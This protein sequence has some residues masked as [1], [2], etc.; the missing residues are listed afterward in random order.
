MPV[1]VLVVVGG[2]VIGW[3][4]GGRLRAL[5]A[6]PL[7][8]FALLVVALA[9]QLAGFLLAGVAAPL[10]PA[11]LAL[12]AVLAAAFLT[13]NPR[14]PGGSLV[15][16]GLF[17]NAAVIAANG[18]MPVSVTAAARARLPL[19]RLSGDPR[20]QLAGPDTALGSLADVVPLP[21]PGAE[22]VLSPG[23]ILVLAGLG[24]GVASGMRRPVRG[25]GRRHRGAPATKDALPGVGE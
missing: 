16:A 21:L 6:L 5:A 11:G 7:R 1:L 12:S 25:P 18:S 22:Q 3:L 15:L 13:A 4:L 23:D 14:L 20:H 24:L 9:A 2:A 10:Y 17:L 19:T 8:R